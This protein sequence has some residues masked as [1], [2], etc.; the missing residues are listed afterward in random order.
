MPHPNPRRGVLA[1]FL[2]LFIVLF[3]AAAPAI[4]RH[5]PA[6]GSAAVAAP[7][8]FGTRTA[9]AVIRRGGNAVDAAV[10]T[11][12][13]LAVTYPEAGNLGGG[14]FMMIYMHGQPAFLDYRETA[15]AA[16]TRDMY[17]D[18]KGEVIKD[19]S[20]VGPR[21]A[22]VPGT[23][24]GLW[25]AHRRY[26]KRPWH[27]LLQ[28]AIRLAR[29]GFTVPLHMARRVEELR[30]S[31]EG[32]TNFERYFGNVHGAEIFRQPEL[33]A[34]L[35]RIAT[36]GAREF[37]H[38]KTAQLLVAQMKKDGGLIS[39]QDLADYRAKWREPLVADWRDLKLLTAPL[40]SSGGF[41]LIELLEMHDVLSAQ[42][43]GLAHN[44]TQYVHLIAEMEKRVF[45]DR[46]EYLGDPDFVQ[47]P[48]E[49]LIAPDYIM[50]RAAEVRP[51]EI[52]P[53]Q[54]V[55]PGLEEG[56]NTTHFSIL[57]A[58]GN[59]VSN[60]YTLNEWYGNGEVVEGA[61]FLLNDEM[62]DFSIKAGVP[63]S[64]GVVGGDANAIAP[65]KRMLSS[66]SP[67]IALRDGKV[68]LVAGTPGGST[69][70]TS[71]FQVMLNLYD[72][73]MTPKEAVS[74]GR[75]HHQ[76][77]PPDRIIYSVCCALP[78]D[79]LDG[80]RALGYKPEQ[81]PW[82]FGDVQVITVDH[83][84][85]VN[86]GSDPRGRGAALVESIALS[87]P[88]RRAARKSSSVCPAGQPCA[89]ATH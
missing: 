35:A 66:M 10:A 9:L 36:A 42:F 67:T 78:N 7:D 22:G 80:L 39:A 13:V 86:A 8:E 43:E 64:Y 60:T 83:D 50:R 53:V 88:A 52:S 24:A 51:H 5:P 70:F 74:A 34:T 31:Y 25:L 72:F 57:D 1:S 44:S 6:H 49:K 19:A 26:G 46:A 69:I 29:N 89:S 11:A 59:A 85:A 48:I 15:P 37:Y 73:H 16:A 47:V 45:A 68:A 79:T 18:D 54:S 3:A 12:F 63:N 17:L 14:G 21:A 65:G 28:P 84:G 58:E 27:E 32:H 23:V 75:F 71:V 76:L 38:G 40:P 20:I 2:I 81:S 41:A 82:E 56:H 30:P 87:A 62:D 61:G 33:A 77:L 4:A 55:K